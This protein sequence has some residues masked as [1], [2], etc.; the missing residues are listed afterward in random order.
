M[1]SSAIPLCCTDGYQPTIHP[2]CTWV[3]DIPSFLSPPLLSC[4]NF[5][6]EATLPISQA[7][8]S[9][10]IRKWQI[11]RAVEIEDTVFALG[12]KSNTKKTKG[13]SGGGRGRWGRVSKTRL[14]QRTFPHRQP[15]LG[16]PESWALPLSIHMDILG[17]PSLPVA[18]S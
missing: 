2:G 15:S 4:T 18:P 9:K 7:S 6:N 5:Q 17:I 3:P 16:P 10:L 11:L 12:K 1:T 8:N 14:V 13:W